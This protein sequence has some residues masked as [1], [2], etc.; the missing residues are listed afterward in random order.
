[1]KAV[2]ILKLLKPIHLIVLTIQLILVSAIITI[3]IHPFFQP[4]AVQN[5]QKPLLI[6]TNIKQIIERK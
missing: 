4:F 3:N 5:V 6:K 1:M 2:F